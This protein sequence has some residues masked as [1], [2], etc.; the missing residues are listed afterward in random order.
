LQADERSRRHLECAH[1]GV[2]ERPLGVAARD[3]DGVTRRTREAA[4]GGGEAFGRMAPR[5][6]GGPG[7]YH[8]IR[9]IYRS[10]KPHNEYRFSPENRSCR[11]E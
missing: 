1:D 8:V 7:M 2:D 5:R 6:R 11:V 9:F 3:D 4:R 10:Y